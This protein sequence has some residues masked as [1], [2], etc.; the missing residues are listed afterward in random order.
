[1]GAGTDG[2]AGCAVTLVGGRRIVCVTIGD[3]RAILVRRDV[4][5]VRLSRDRK[6]GILDE[7]RRISEYCVEWFFLGTMAGRGTTSSIT[8]CW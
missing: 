5:M 8:K 1:V 4:T 7:K 2:T 3:S 6:P